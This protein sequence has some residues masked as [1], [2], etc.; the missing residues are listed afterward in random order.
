MHIA[1]AF[2]KRWYFVVCVYKIEDDFAGSAAVQSDFFFIY[3]LFI[4]SQY[5]IVCVKI[6]EC[7]E[8]GANN[9]VPVTA[10]PVMH[11]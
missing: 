5:K 6:I 9:N 8:N 2:C 10:I 1:T 4:F 7:P 3:Q 11:N